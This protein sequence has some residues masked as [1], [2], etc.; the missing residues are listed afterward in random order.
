MNS[1][2]LLK[3]ALGN[4]WK[5]K[6]RTFLTIL[7]VIIGTSSIVIMMSLGIAMDRKLKEQLE[8]MGELNIM[9]IY[10][11]EGYYD[12]GMGGGQNRQVSLDDQT[13]ASFKQIPGVEAVMPIKSAHYKMGVGRMVGYV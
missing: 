12:D 6:T 10:N 9:E 13:V 2:D 4:L 3:M 7:G 5:R 1:S 8:Q 11:Y